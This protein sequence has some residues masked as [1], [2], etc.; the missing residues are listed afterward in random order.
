MRRI[1]QYSASKIYPQ[2]LLHTLRLIVKL[3]AIPIHYIGV[4]DIMVEGIGWAYHSAVLNKYMKV[5]PTQMVEDAIG[6]A[7]VTPCILQNL[8]ILVQEIEKKY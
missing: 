6:V 4:D 8:P 2:L 5:F 1:K 3:P 7:V